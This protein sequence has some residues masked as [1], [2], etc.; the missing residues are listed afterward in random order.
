MSEITYL[1]SGSICCDLNTLG[2]ALN[3]VTTKMVS[4]YSITIP[5]Q[6]VYL[7]RQFKMVTLNNYACAH[8]LH[9]SAQWRELKKERINCE[10]TV[11]IT[12][13][14]AKQIYLQSSPGVRFSLKGKATVQQEGTKMCSTFFYK[15]VEE[16]FCLGFDYWW[17]YQIIS[18]FDEIHT[19]PRV[20]I[21]VVRSSLKF[22]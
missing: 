18:V 10:K 17:Q 9:A 11:G 7:I 14:C 16:P 8:H 21:K 13:G 20:W 15:A 22:S 19:F 6:V 1:S 4:S 5:Y 3:C 12:S 2:T